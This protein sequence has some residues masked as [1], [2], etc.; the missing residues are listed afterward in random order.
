MANVFNEIDNKNPNQPDTPSDDPYGGFDEVMKHHAR[1]GA[2]PMSGGNDN[3]LPK[4]VKERLS[5]RRTA[6]INA[7]RTQRPSSN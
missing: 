7:P 5:G 1:P 4:L 2:V 3:A 6:K